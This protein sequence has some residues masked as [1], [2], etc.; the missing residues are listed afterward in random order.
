MRHSFRSVARHLAV[1]PIALAG[2]G[3]AGAQPAVMT[4][5]STACAT[6]QYNSVGP[7]YTESGFTLFTPD[8]F[9]AWCADADGYAGTGMWIGVNTPDRTA[10][11]TRNNGG[12]FSIT[13]IDLAHLYSGT[14]GPQSFTF[15][16]NLYDG[17]TVSQTFTIGQEFG[18]AVFSPYAFDANWTNL[19]SVGF[20]A[21]DYPYYQFT[22][23]LLEATA[24]PEPASI[25]LLATGLVG[26]FGAARRLNKSD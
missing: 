5:A 8:G 26:V 9:I 12:T 14:W 13:G 6:G 21:Q 23:I 11:L 16:G 25:T 20:A 4:F 10:L 3:V 7:A 24:V 18:K 22:N 15:V 1:F 19:I 17:G 2:S